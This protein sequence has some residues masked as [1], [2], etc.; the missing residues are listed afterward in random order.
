VRVIFLDVDG[1]LNSERYAL[2]LEAKHRQLG[3]TEPASPKRETT[4]DCFKLYHQIDREAVTR[5]NRLVAA[6]DAKIVVSSTW[7]KLF[8]PPD[9][10]W[11]LEEH[12]FVGEIVGETP[13]GHDEPEM[14]TVYGHLERMYRG[15]EIDF[16]LRK[17]PEVDRFVI[18]D[19]GSDM[20]MHG[21]RLVQTDYDDGLCDEHVELAIRVMAWDGTSQPSPVEEWAAEMEKASDKE[22]ER[23]D[24]AGGYVAGP[25]TQFGSSVGLHCN[26]NQHQRDGSCLERLGLSRV[27]TVQPTHEDDYQ[28]LM[29]A[30]AEAAV[31]LGWR[32]HQCVWW[33]PTHVVAKNLA[34][35]CCL[36]ACPAC[37]CIGGPFADAVDG[38][39][40]ET[41][42]RGTS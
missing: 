10:R 18:L 33:C 7:R 20:A 14:V 36:S 39:V 17:H 24:A 11:I 15:Y 30:I 16:W 12:G 35:K 19:D 21:S 23:Q 28:S 9:L 32:L 3:H 5:L 34:C 8:D 27:T 37:S 2:K 22:E 31:L 38:I 13:D 1:V 26:H 40:I 42:E 6:T 4:C 29:P 41:I 25:T